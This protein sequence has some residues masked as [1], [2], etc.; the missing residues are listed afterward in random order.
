[1]QHDMRQ[2]LQRWLSLQHGSPRSMP[3]GSSIGLERGV[4]LKHLK[5]LALSPPDGHDCWK[6]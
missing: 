3:P 1:M 5:Q 2:Q 6:L 4:Q